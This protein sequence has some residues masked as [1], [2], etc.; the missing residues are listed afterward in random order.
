M[1]VT[2]ST[3]DEQINA[4]VEYSRKVLAERAAR[5]V[6]SQ[7]IEGEDMVR[8]AQEVW[9]AEALRTAQL[10]YRHVCQH[11][12]STLALMRCLFDIVATSI[13]GL[14]LSNDSRRAAQD[15]VREWAKVQMDHVAR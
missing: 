2:R 1:N 15:V 14:S 8:L 9:N 3:T 11:T 13:T 5:A 7:F 12:D 10:R 4:G 6:S